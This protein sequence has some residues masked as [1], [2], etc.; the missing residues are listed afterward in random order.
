MIFEES[1]SFVDIK[2]VFLNLKVNSSEVPTENQ[3]CPQ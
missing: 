1:Q 2:I 3:F